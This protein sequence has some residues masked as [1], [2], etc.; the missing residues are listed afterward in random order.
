MPTRSHAKAARRSPSCSSSTPTVA[1]CSS[2]RS[3]STLASLTRARLSERPARRRDT[4]VGVDRR[5]RDRLQPLNKET[6]LDPLAFTR[7]DHRNAAN[8]GASEATSRV[9]I[10]TDTGVRSNERSASASSGLRPRRFPNRHSP[11]LVQG[12]DAANATK[13]LARNPGSPLPSKRRDYCSRTGEGVAAR[14]RVATAS[15]RSRPSGP[16]EPGFWFVAAAGPRP[17]AAAIDRR[18]PGAA[19]LVHERALRV[20]DALTEQA[21][22]VPLGDPAVAGH[23]RSLLRSSA[24]ERHH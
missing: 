8:A 10:W 13:L 3:A 22:G 5:G 4:A 11:Y 12:S 19:A 18:V 6:V 9:S 17:V 24:G 20:S 1:S 14:T 7:A 2:A 16:H 15:E 21:E 23:R